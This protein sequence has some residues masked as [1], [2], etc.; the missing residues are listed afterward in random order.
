KVKDGKKLQAALDQ[1]VKSLLKLA[2][3]EAVLRK[4]TY[5]GGPIREG[6]VRT[7]GFFFV[8]TYAIHDGWL[9]VG[10]VPQAVQRV[11]ARAGGKL[12][13]WHPS[14][15]DRARLE[16]M[17]KSGLGMSYSDPRP[18]VRFLLSLAPAAGGALKSFAA[19]VPFEVDTI[20]N[21]QEVTRFL[22]PSVS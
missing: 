3:K 15:Q 20:P 17:P 21:A 22:F 2:G 5:H 16:G 1:A 7:P 10:L 9:A 12:E 8:P 4:R 6:Q 18:T 13:R 11:V 19:E 14:D